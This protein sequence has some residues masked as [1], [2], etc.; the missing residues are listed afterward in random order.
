MKWAIDRIENN[1]A[2]IENIFTKQKQ[3]IPLNELPVSSQEGSIL[4]LKNKHYQ[5]DHQAEITRKLEIKE[6]F[7][8][9]RKNQN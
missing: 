6:K 2:I 3:E 5:L 7:K 8:K 9:L 4:I 1:I